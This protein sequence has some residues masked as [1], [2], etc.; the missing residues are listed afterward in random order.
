MPQKYLELDGTRVMLI[1]NM[2]FDP[3]HGLHKTAEE[4]RQ[5]GVLVEDVP[6]PEQRAGKLP[7]PCYTPERGVYYEYADKPVEP[8]EALNAKLDYMMMMQGVN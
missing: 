1:H 5:T 4:L 2:P 8:V 6:Q 7:L 3:V